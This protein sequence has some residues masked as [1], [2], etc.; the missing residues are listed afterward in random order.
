[1]L[2]RILCATDGSKVSERAVAFAIDLAKRLD[3][4]LTFLTVTTVTAELAARSRLLGR[5]PAL[6]RRRAAAPRA[7]RGGAAGR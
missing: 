4:H 1:M 5:H 2:S 6:G 7:H 3:A